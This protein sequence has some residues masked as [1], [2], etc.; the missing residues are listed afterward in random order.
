MS[1]LRDIA[2]PAL[3]PTSSVSV[4]NAAGAAS[5]ARASSVVAVATPSDT[6]VIDAA[7]AAPVAGVVTLLELGELSRFV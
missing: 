2:S 6:P 1:G 7:A 5:V 3:P 4:A